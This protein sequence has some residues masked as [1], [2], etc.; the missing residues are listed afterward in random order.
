MDSV[1]VPGGILF[2]YDGGVLGY[3]AD[4]MLGLYCFRVSVV[5]CREKSIPTPALLMF[6]G[7]TLI[8]PWGNFCNCT[9]SI[10]GIIVILSPVLP[11]IA[12]WH[13]C[14]EHYRQ[15]PCHSLPLVVA[16]CLFLP[17]LPFEH[18]KHNLGSP[19]E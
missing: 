1:R 15:H 4:S 13:H 17:L 18:H 19:S 6:R 8:P 14:L 3:W 11:P 16:N 10:Q 2:I 7:P 12:L 5:L 9:R